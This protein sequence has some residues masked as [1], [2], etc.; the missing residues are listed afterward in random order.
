[1][2]T[3]P[4]GRFLGYTPKTNRPIYLQQGGSEPP[5]Q[6]P[7]VPSPAQVF[8]QGVPAPL[9]TQEQLEA[10]RARVRA[11]EKA[12]LYPRIEQTA[13]Q[14]QA[15][16]E[17]VAGLRT[18]DQARDAEA[19]ALA[20][21][22]AAAAKKREEDELSVRQ[23]FERKE[24]EWETRFNTER[25]ARERQEALLAKE[26]EYSELEKYKARRVAEVM[27]KD[28]II[29]EFADLITGTTP[30]EVEQ[31]LTNLQEKT[32]SILEGIQQAQ[33]ASR[34][35]MPGVSSAAGNTG[36]L[37]AQPGQRTYSAADIAAMPPGSPEHLAARAAAGIRTPG[38]GEGLFG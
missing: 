4:A 11:E 2:T 36:P 12:K 35:A 33:T 19:N 28:L 3:T 5:V 38:R 31:S 18:K 15:L 37:E 10:E 9:Y 34:S 20:E 32:V 8:P 17:E 22:E 26:R 23:L 1:M 27:A 21:A 13:A 6:P 16:Q 7:V 25:E 30:E 14:Y 24:Q 29:P